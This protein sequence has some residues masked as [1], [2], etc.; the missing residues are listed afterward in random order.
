MRI[1]FICGSLEI[2]R[3]GVGDYIR[4]LAAG[5]INGGNE[6]AAVALNDCFVYEETIANQFFEG[7]V[8]PTLRV[9]A[10]WPNRIRYKRAKVWIDKF[11]PEWLSLQF[12]PFA[13]HNKGIT[14][15][16]NKN[17]KTLGKGRSWHIMFHELWV[18]MEIS[19]DLKHFLWGRLQRWLIKLLLDNLKPS[20]VHTQTKLYQLQLLK[21]GFKAA[22]LPLFSN[23]PLISNDRMDVNFLR[24]APGLKKHTISLV[25]FG[26]I[27]PGAPIK[28]FCEEAALYS[29]HKRVKVCLTILG[30]G[31][32]ERE[33]WAT[34]W[35]LQ[36]LEVN[37]LGELPAEQISEVLFKAS[38][39]IT[40]NPVTLIEKSGTVA[41]MLEHGLPVICV[42]K[43]WQPDEIACTKEPP[44]IIAYT[45]GN[46]EECFSL[47]KMPPIRNKV[48][49]VT[50]Q[51]IGTLSKPVCYSDILMQ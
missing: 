8:L 47:N 38:I 30:I 45:A 35:R 31:G 40:T 12:V 29:K 51:F 36:G 9:P 11:D 22:Y 37:A 28:R 46:I 21:L 2:G 13:F 10:V 25:I 39:G 41:A 18:G 15:S 3:D 42:S 50:D 16:L 6:A 33:R 7:I 24:S 5:L 23:I 32:K 17:L 4:R 48:F 26:A 14:Y 34:L 44:G 20:V 27:H 49:E 19:S 43:Q 1:I